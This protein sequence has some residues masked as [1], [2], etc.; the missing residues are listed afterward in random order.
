VAPHQCFEGIQIL[1]ADE[2]YQA[3]VR[4]VTQGVPRVGAA[5]LRQL[6]FAF[7]GR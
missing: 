4:Q 2:L 5:R 6:D 7:H 3:V 1:C